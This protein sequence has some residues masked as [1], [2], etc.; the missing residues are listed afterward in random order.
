MKVITPQEALEGLKALGFKFDATRRS[1]DVLRNDS[2]G[3]P[4]S[5]TRK[6]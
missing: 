5:G 4:V 3:Y 1:L 2:D 6:V